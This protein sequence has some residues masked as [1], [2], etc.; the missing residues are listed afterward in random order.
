MGLSG[1]AMK[2][3]VNVEDFVQ[4]LTSFR[5]TDYVNLKEGQ[6]RALKGYAEHILES[7]L[8]IELPTGYG[9]TLVAL[10]IA[11][12][13]LEQGRRVAYLT[14]TNQLADQVLHQ[15]KALQGLL[16]AKFF[17]QHYPPFD[18]ANYHD[19]KAIGVMNYWTYFNAA[20]RVEPAD[21]IIFD[22]A[23]LAEQPLVERFAIRIDR[24]RNGDLYESLCDL[25]LAYTDLYPSI[26]LMRTGQSSVSDPPELLTFR[27]WDGVRERAAA[28]IQGGLNES[29]RQFV[30]PS[31]SQH[32]EACGVLFGP[33]AIEIRPYH[34]PTQTLPG[35][36][37]SKQ[38][39]YMSATLGTM[40]DLQRRLGVARPVNVMDEPVAEDKTGRRLFLINPD[41]SVRSL[42][43]AFDFALSQ[44]DRAGRVVWLCSSTAEADRTESL[45]SDRGI[46]PHRLRRH[47]EDQILRDWGQDPA[48]HLLMAGRYDGFDLAGDLCRLVILP[49]VPT[50]STEFERFV[51]AYLG[52]ATYMRHRVG[53]RISQALGRANRDDEDWAMYLAL[54]PNFSTLLAQSSVRDAIPPIV[55]PVVDQALALTA[56]GW[57]QVRAAADAFWESNGKTVAIGTR[58]G[59]GGSVRIRPGRVQAASTAGSAD[60]EVSAITNLWLGDRHAAAEMA[61][62][63]AMS[64]GSAGEI[65]HSAFWRYVQAHAVYLKGG[66]AALGEAMD[67]LRQASAG[68]PSTTWFIRLRRLLSE[69][70]EAQAG[71]ADEQPWA[72]WDQWIRDAGIAR[73]EQAV[74]RCRTGLMG[75]HDQQ[76]E[77]LEILG[78]IAGVQASRPF[79]EG[80]TDALWIWSGSRK[81]EYRSW[82]VKSGDQ[83]KIPLKWVT[84]ALGQVETAKS[85]STTR[86]NAVG[87]IVTTA[88]E[89]DESALSAARSLCLIH[90]DAV[91]RFAEWAGDRLIEYAK[92]SGSGTASERGEARELVERSMPTEP[93]ASWLGALVRPSSGRVLTADEIVRRL[94]P[95]TLG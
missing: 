27:H 62:R 32:L 45:L 44:A 78:R 89:V 36:R 83:S 74:S 76:A 22:D 85:E 51:M 42:D 50:G 26:K 9:K 34:P 18:L 41:D 64:L 53:Q 24:K 92:H 79:G 77:S 33:S 87:S 90:R 71:Q 67:I 13:V 15:A 94:P 35:Y 65:E 55:K 23:H 8:A 48:G 14:G 40:D 70:R 52:D 28:L 88:M 61:A 66:P 25:V 86:A 93:W 29:D 21:V 10:L 69:L 59:V 81:V 95:R 56:G 60:D 91:V 47:A 63:A 49:T 31:V 82:E 72:A 17:S 75:T 58:P 16:S 1:R 73:V 4:R 57:P 43:Q 30:W 19:A 5:S 46:D 6:K 39:I 38:R 37:Q 68:G 3:R 84:Q 54:A 80:K 11:D 2:R 7:D 20:P 12:M